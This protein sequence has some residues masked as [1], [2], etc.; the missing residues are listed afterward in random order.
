MNPASLKVGETYETIQ[1]V[2]VCHY[3]TE[4]ACSLQNSIPLPANE[5][6]TY[7]KFDETDD[8]YVFSDVNGTLYCLHSDDLVYIKLAA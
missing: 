5:A 4:G 3:S 8:G 6:L 7:V 1:Q 2:N